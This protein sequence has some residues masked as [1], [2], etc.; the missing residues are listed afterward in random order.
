M[1]FTNNACPNSD[2]KVKNSRKLRQIEWERNV[3]GTTEIERPAG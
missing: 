3:L 1:T 2:I